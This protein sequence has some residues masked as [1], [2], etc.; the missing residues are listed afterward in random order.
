MKQPG[1]LDFDIRLNSI[2]TIK[3]QRIYD[4]KMKVFLAPESEKKNNPATSGQ[5][6]NKH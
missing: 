4:R 6:G 5:R 1:F 2:T 3:F